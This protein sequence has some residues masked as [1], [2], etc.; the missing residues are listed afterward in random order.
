[1]GLASYYRRFIKNFSQIA[2]P[3]YNL[4]KKD[5]NYEWTEERQQVFQ[6]LKN[7]LISAPLLAYP[8]FDKSFILFTDA[9]LAALGAVIEQMGEDGHRHPIAYAS[10]STN[11]AER[12]YSSTELECAAVVWAINYFQPYL[13]G[14][15]FTIYTDH[16][17]LQWLLKLKTIKNGLT[18]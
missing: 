2:T 15:H 1:M 4:L 3:L 16:S 10:R 7:R 13:Y 5:I 11:T 9:S 6:Q 17:A 18:G 12:K 14:K 8:D